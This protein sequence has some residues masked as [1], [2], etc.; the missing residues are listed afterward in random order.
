VGAA[1]PNAILERLTN[2]PEARSAVA[3]AGLT[4]RD[5]TLS[6]VALLQAAMVSQVRARGGSV[7]VPV[8]EG[9]VRLVTENWEE[10]EG[11]MRRTMERAGGP[12]GGGG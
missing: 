7:P 5:Y 11:L 12:G 8:N 3:R 1:D 6:T 9:N 4:P 2:V 10:I